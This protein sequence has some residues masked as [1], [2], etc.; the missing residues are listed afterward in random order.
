M[1]FEHGEKAVETKHEGTGNGPSSPA[2]GEGARI[3]EE[4]RVKAQAKAEEASSRMRSWADSGRAEVATQLGGVARALHSASEQLRSEEQGRAGY[5]TDLLGEQADQLAHYLE[6]HDA[7]DLLGEV[8]DFARRQPLLFLGGCAAAGFALGRFF[9]ASPRPRERR[10]EAPSEPTPH[11]AHT[12][13]PA[14]EPVEAAP[15]EPVG[16]EPAT[17][18]PAGGTPIT[19]EPVGGEATAR[20]ASEEGDERR[21]GE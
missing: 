8:E 20:G 12:G 18:Q 13:L 15:G 5:Y 6:E 19:G 7:T 3:R 21:E 16:G 11:L 1:D 9:K 17:G 2:S 10:L 4:A 14:G